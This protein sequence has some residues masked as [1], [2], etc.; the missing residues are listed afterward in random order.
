MTRKTMM[1][2]WPIK[3]QLLDGNLENALARILFNVVPHTSFPRFTQNAAALNPEDIRWFA[4]TILHHEDGKIRTLR[5]MDNDIV[6]ISSAIDPFKRYLL[7]VDI[8][9]TA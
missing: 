3:I 9:I 5:S 8:S 1:V 6:T 7:Q 2:F 4:I